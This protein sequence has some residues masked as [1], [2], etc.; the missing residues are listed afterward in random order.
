MRRWLVAAVVVVGCAG[1]NVAAAAAFGGR[2]APSVTVAGAVTTPATY[3]VAQL[4]SLPQTT[5]TVTAG[6]RASALTRMWQS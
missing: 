5:F 3:S 6:S 2:Q 1:L 4:G